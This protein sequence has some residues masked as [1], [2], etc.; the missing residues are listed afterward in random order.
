MLGSRMQQVGEDRGGPSPESLLMMKILPSRPKATLPRG[1]AR[2]VS[3]D[4]PSRWDL[5]PAASTSVAPRLCQF[6][7]AKSNNHESAWVVSRAWRLPGRSSGLP[8]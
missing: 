5:G 4:R 1:G 3:L 2:P 6:L 7:V 8:C